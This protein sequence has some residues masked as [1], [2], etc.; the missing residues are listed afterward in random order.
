MVE[1][2]YL[3]RKN[4]RQI[5]STLQYVGYY[6]KSLKVK[7]AE[8]IGKHCWDINREG[9]MSLKAQIEALGITIVDGNKYEN[10]PKVS[11][12]TQSPDE[13][14]DMKNWQWPLSMDISSTAYHPGQ[15]VVMIDVT[16][17]TRLKEPYPSKCVDST[18]HRDLFSSKYNQ[19]TCLETCVLRNLLKQC[20]DVVPYWQKFVSV[21]LE[22]NV[23]NISNKE[24]RRCMKVWLSENYTD[25][26]CGQ[27]CKEVLY[28]LK[29]HPYASLD[30]NQALFGNASI[31]YFVIW[32]ANHKVKIVTEK[33]AYTFFE[34]SADLG[35][36][37]GLLLGLSVMSFFEFFAFIVVCLIS[38][39]KQRR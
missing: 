16:K 17:F 2:Q 35:G 38:V 22:R 14:K 13:S 8:R 25:C 7:K 29:T 20:G 6:Y 24:R 28:S 18:E 5:V 23:K 36:H 10:L 26:H 3:E 31:W 34:F 27:Q 12:F 15:Y 30:F 19:K 1:K 11:I 9:N 39:I 21:D 4:V 33:P 37:F 32:P